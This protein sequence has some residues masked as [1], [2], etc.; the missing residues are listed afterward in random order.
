MVRHKINYRCSSHLIQFLF[1]FLLI[2]RRFNYRRR[3]V[4]EW[5]LKSRARFSSE[6]IVFSFLSR[7]EK[8]LFLLLRLLLFFFNVAS[9][10]ISDDS[11]IRYVCGSLCFWGILLLFV[12]HFERSGLCLRWFRISVFG[13]LWYGIRAVCGLLLMDGYCNECR[14]V[15]QF[16]WFC[17]YVSVWPV[18]RRVIIIPSF[19]LLKLWCLL[20]KVLDTFV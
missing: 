4:K 17:V 16:F 10:V 18:L 2:G 1:L 13:F 6:M 11:A 3:K 15:V 19:L 5:A 12:C 7:R 20:V 9:T 8:F 14:W